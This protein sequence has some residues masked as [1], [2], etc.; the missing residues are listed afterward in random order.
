MFC[1]SVL[2]DMRAGSYALRAN[3]KKIALHRFCKPN[4]IQDAYCQFL[5]LQCEMDMR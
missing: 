4:G 3:R 5:S 2:S 1:M